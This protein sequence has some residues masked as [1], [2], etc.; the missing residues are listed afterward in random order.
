MKRMITD[1][2]KCLPNNRPGKMPRA[3][4]SEMQDLKTFMLLY[5]LFDLGGDLYFGFWLC[6]ICIC[7]FNV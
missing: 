5:F 2:V 7:F 1:T 4:I 6:F 3:V